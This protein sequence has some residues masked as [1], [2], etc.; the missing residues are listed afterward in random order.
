M[1]KK[2]KFAELTEA[3]GLM[4]KSAILRITLQSLIS[5]GHIQALGDYSESIGQ[6]ISE[7]FKSLE[8]HGE[9]IDDNLKK[10]HTQA[11]FYIQEEI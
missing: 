9:D 7:D 5:V 8:A 11:K 2:I 4:K 6:S 1:K 10:R 3:C